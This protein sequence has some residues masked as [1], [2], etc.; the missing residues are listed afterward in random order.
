MIMKS[1]LQVIVK[2]IYEKY[3]LLALKLF[4]IA[5]HKN[6]HGFDSWIINLSYYTAPDIPSWVWIC[7]SVTLSLIGAFGIFSNLIVII[8]YIKNKSVGK[9]QFFVIVVALKHYH[10][11][12]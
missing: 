11:K 10:T 12:L 1:S 7:S 9:Q 4:Y 5:E 2:C 3:L 6:D 8:A